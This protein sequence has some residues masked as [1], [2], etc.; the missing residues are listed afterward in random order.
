[1]IFSTKKTPIEL[2]IKTGNIEIIKIFLSH[3]EIKI[4]LNLK[5]QLILSALNS[6]NAEVIK[7]LYKKGENNWVQNG[8][9]KIIIT[10]VM[11]AIIMLSYLF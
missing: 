6:N 3:P 10:I 11:I 2:A 9:S 4:N 7:I 8:H 1:M 5:K